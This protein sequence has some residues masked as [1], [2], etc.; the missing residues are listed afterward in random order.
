MAAQDIKLD[1]NDLYIDVNTGDFSIGN[2]DTQHVQD[3]INSFVGWWKEYPTL[4]VGIK[5]YLGRSGGVQLTKRA[6]KIHLKSDGYR[7]D[8]IAVQDNSVYVTG[9]RIIK[10]V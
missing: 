3:I 1:D 2:S 4:G 8:K 10:V 5:K 7:A 9:E 6:I